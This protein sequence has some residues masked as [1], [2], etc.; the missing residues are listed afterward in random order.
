MK[1]LKYRICIVVWCLWAL[2][3]GGLA[4]LSGGRELGAVAG[5]AA[6]LAAPAFLLQY[7]LVGFWNPARL[8]RT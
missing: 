3:I 8:W 4:L 7:L 6:F 2:C 5:A 1:P